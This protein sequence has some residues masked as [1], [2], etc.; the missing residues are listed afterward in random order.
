MSHLSFALARLSTVG[1]GVAAT[2]LVSVAMVAAK[3]NFMV[4]DFLFWECWH[5]LQ[6]EGEDA[7]FNMT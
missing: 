5:F 3:R 7:R 2:R 1:V 4:G 6:E